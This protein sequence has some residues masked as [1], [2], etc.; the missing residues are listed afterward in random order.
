MKQQVWT[1]LAP[2][3]LGKSSM[4]VILLSILGMVPQLVHSQVVNSTQ[5]PEQIAVLHWYPANLTTT[6]TVGTEPDGM[7]FDGANI[8]VANLGSNNV[9][10]LQ[11]STG[12]VLGT[13]AVGT[14]P[15]Y[16]ALDG[17]NI[18]VTNLGSKTVSKL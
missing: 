14:N 18:W 3:P 17:V 8:W 15:I 9:T 12:K 4:V 13:F 10:K 6:S 11:A 16:A 7:A 1:I 5:N 2:P